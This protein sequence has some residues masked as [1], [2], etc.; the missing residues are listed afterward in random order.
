MSS[1]AG[2]ANAPPLKPEFDFTRLAYSD[3]NGFGF[4]GFGRR[5]G[6]W[7]TDAPEAEEHFLQ[8]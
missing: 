2:E 8:V 5:G 1:A 4:G 7:T 6:S 3:N